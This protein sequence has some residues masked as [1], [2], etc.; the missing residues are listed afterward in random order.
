MTAIEFAFIPIDIYWT[1]YVISPLVVP[2]V[3]S[4]NL[5]FVRRLF[6][7]PDVEVSGPQA[8]PALLSVA[9]AEV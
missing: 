7:V 8:T 4:Q 5:S 1:L 3:I 6:G 9:G 2:T